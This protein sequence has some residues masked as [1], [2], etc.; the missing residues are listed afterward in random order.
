MMRTDSRGRSASPHRITY[1]SD[2]HTIKCSFDGTSHHGAGSNCGSSPSGIPSSLSDPMLSHTS[3]AAATTT[4]TA[5]SSN[6]S[7][8]SGSLTRGRVTSARGPKIRD[9][10]F[11]QMDSQQ[12]CQEGGFL[13][14]S[15]SVP[16]LSPQPPRSQRQPSPLPP[17]RRSYQLVSSLGAL[18]SKTSLSS[19]DSPGVPAAKSS[20]K[21]S[22][23][24]IAEIDRVA[25]AE[26]FSVARKLFETKAT[27]L[28]GE[29]KARLTA[30][31]GSKELVNDQGVAYEVEVEER[32]ARGN[33]SQ[34]EEDDK[35]LSPG[36][37][38]QEHEGAEMKCS[39]RQIL[40]TEATPPA[41]TS[42][43]LDPRD[44]QPSSPSPSAD[45]A[46]RLEPRSPAAAAASPEPRLT[47]SDL[48]PSPEQPVRAELV[49]VKNDSSESEEEVAEVKG[50]NEGLQA[51]DD[52]EKRVTVEAAAEASEPLVD[53]VFEG[54]S[55][56]TC[57]PGLLS[58]TIVSGDHLPG[59]PLCHVSKGGSRSD[60]TGRDEYR[61]ATECSNTEQ[62]DTREDG[63]QSS[64]GK[65]KTTAAD[66]ILVASWLDKGDETFE[67]ETEEFDGVE[68]S[69]REDK[70]R[71][72]EEE[73]EG[74]A[75][76]DMDQAHAD[77]H[78]ELAEVNSRGT[79]ADPKCEGEADVPNN[80]DESA[81]AASVHGIENEAF[82]DDHDGDSDGRSK[83]PR[84]EQLNYEEI[85]GLP[86][87]SD[88]EGEEEEEEEEEEKEKEK[89]E[90][91]VG[92]GKRRVHFS[93]APIRVYNTYSNATYDRRNEGIDPVLASA[94][95]ELEKRV[96][97]MDVFAVEIEKGEDGLGIS[98]IGMGVGADQ[99]LEKLGIFVKSVTEGGATQQDGSIRVNDQIV[100]VDGVSLVGVSQ[101]F[102]ATVL[103]NTSGLVKFLIGREMQGVE[104]EVARLINE[105]L[106]MESS[107]E[108]HQLCIKYQQLRAKLQRK[109]A[110]LR[111]ATEKLKERGEQ[112][113]DWESQRTEWEQR[114]ED[115]EDKAQ[116]LEKYW[117]EAQTLCR[118]VSQRLADAQSQSESL[119]IKYGKAKRLVREYQ[120][121]VDEG[122]RREADLQQDLEEQESRHREMVERLQA[123]QNGETTTTTTSEETPSPDPLSTDWCIPDTGRLDSSALRAKA[124]LAQK[125]KRHPPSRDKLRESFK[126]Q[127]NS[128]SVGLLDSQS[129][130]ALAAGPRG[131]GSDRTTNTSSSSALGP[132]V[133]TPRTRSKRRFPDFSV[134]RKSLNRRSVKI[135][136]SSSDKR[137]LPYLTTTGRRDQSVG[138]TVGT[139]SLA[140]LVSDRSFS[141]HSHNI[142]FSSTETL[143][144]DLV[145]VHN[146]NQWQSRPLLEWTNQQVCLW[147]TGMNMDQYAAEFTAR[148]VE[149][150]QL[151]G[152]DSDKLKALGV[153]ESLL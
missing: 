2:F 91:P 9:N 73:E 8:N 100:D 146:N 152:L 88:Q 21:W 131:S 84:P 18:G 119:E 136:T 14:T 72:E 138:S 46:N 95:Y 54:P 112:Q 133:L 128:E 7:S 129:M 45:P 126:Q 66:A 37:H 31:R 65:E 4:S 94:E 58:A 17:S 116:K 25:L 90:C 57:S 149:G 103:K 93:T 48:S 105:S 38:N 39:V 63:T 151:L 123:L 26:T 77:L 20:H 10:I 137:S 89:E 12:H 111:H 87:L 124:Q 15:C 6:S 85:P 52:T 81:A 19:L 143:D 104:S 99:G 34:L 36:K 51:V 142:T 33:V 23:Q 113:A 61:Q 78:E 75:A 83:S 55:I 108:N 35:S 56:E 96:D 1:K 59:F 44:R 122:E 102:A 74:V 86:E 49:D 11:L 29:Q 41:C 40:L 101:M 141:G 121:R 107:L 64:T 127:G 80:G 147:L 106:E 70:G 27:E 117:Q 79:R 50:K 60:I 153:T 115:G 109:T 13:V 69:Q 132:S 114:V 43:E 28:G 47:P 53:D 5:I 42:E 118:V 16:L 130:P 144:D 22:D 134:I 97:K 24:E 98:I 150:E 3:A 140:D 110:K 92:I 125:A 62:G 145:P 135:L 71:E 76:R 120:N 82:V 148:G 67:M 30:L 139:A 68:D 32:G